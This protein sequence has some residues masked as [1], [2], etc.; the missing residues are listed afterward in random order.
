M[1]TKAF[2]PDQWHWTVSEDGDEIFVYDEADWTIARLRRISQEKPIEELEDT[3]RLIA[4]SP[5]MA[6]CLRDLITVFARLRIEP[7][8]YDGRDIEMLTN[9]IYSALSGG[10]LKQID[11]R[12]DSKLSHPL[13]GR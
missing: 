8:F 3:A 7:T 10:V 13:R 9:K 12:T 11:W 6:G 2:T 5:K 4:A 1:T